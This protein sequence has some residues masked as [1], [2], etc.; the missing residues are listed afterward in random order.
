MTVEVTQADRDAAAAF[1]KLSIDR[2][3]A[4]GKASAGMDDT[5]DNPLIQAF[6][7]HRKAALEGVAGLVEALAFYAEQWDQDVDAERTDAGWVGSVGELEPTGELIADG[8]SKAR[9][10]LA[11]AA[12]AALTDEERARIFEDGW[13]RIK[14]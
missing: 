13:K 8:G 4:G 5:D 11:T 2:I 1:W 6:A 3:M 10:A 12:A 14:P 9:A 7:A